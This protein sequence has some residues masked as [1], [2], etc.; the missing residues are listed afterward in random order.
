MMGSCFTLEEFSQIVFDIP[1]YTGTSG[2]CWR[3]SDVFKSLRLYIGWW[4]NVLGVVAGTIFIVAAWTE[5]LSVSDSELQNLYLAAGTMYLIRGLVLFCRTP[6][7][8][9][10]RQKSFEKSTK[11]L[12]G[13]L[14]RF[15]SDHVSSQSMSVSSNSK[16]EKAESKVDED[17]LDIYIREII[18]TD[19]I[20]LTKTDLGML[21]LQRIGAYDEAILD[22]MFAFVDSD[23][24]GTVDV[25]EFRVF[26][27]QLNPT[28]TRIGRLLKVVKKLMINFN[29]LLLLS[30]ISGSTV[31]LLN[32]ISKR[33][34]NREELWVDKYFTPEM[35]VM[36]AYL[37]GMLYFSSERVAYLQ[38]SYAL[39]EKVRIMM[40]VWIARAKAEQSDEWLQFENHDDFEK[41]RFNRILEEHA[42]F[43][44]KS[45]LDSIYR[46]IDTNHNGKISKAEL[47]DFVNTKKRKTIEIASMCLKD[48]I[49]W[50]NFFWTF[51]SVAYLL[52]AYYV[53]GFGKLCQQVRILPSLQCFAKSVFIAP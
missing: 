45:Q 11:K 52:S 44:P 7:D 24:N 43:I 2:F 17:P 21:L 51:G 41:G 46:V 32:N 25:D 29:W 35:Y 53:N 19:N 50:T 30:F 47:E 39:G 36:W 5:Q 8:I 4:V 23:S 14:R 10:K 6:I 13:S 49:F 16:E 31:S 22:E 20:S 3:Y 40:K 38:H 42:I 48:F 1:A 9:Y 27:Q 15:A 28:S 33:I 26:I 34:G 37:V 18:F 12:L